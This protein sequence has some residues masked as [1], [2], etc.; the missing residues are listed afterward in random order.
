MT[1]PARQNQPIPVFFVL[2]MLVCQFLLQLFMARYLETWIGDSR[3]AW[4]LA[5]LASVPL[6]AALLWP[7][8]SSHRAFLIGQLRP[9]LLRPASVAAAIAVG[10]MMRLAF[11][12]HVVGQATLGAFTADSPAPGVGPFFQFECPPLPSILL[13]L[14]ASALVTPI[15]EEITMRGLV[16][17][18]LVA[19]G[20]VFALL[21]SSLLFALFHPPPTIPFVFAMGLVL[22]GLALRSGSL[23][24]CIIAHATYNAAILID[25]VCLQGQWNPA[26]NDPQLPLLA[27]LSVLTLA[28]ALA[29]IAALLRS[30]WLAPV[31]RTSHPP[32]SG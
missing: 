13:A 16:L 28:A 26:A 23:W 29:G 1:L 10:L 2:L 12:G 31:E 6:L 15:V 3:N 22:A 4:R 14:L 11:W 21:A 24:P 18:G 7:V 25:W 8:L 30:R 9:A 5:Y 19:R 32:A 17:Q 27:T 20:R